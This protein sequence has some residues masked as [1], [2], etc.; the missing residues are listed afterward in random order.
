MLRAALTLGGTIP[1]LAALLSFKSHPAG[2]PPE[3]ASHPR[4]A[5][6]GRA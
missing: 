4:G 6:H 1:A 3:L 5:R 2:S